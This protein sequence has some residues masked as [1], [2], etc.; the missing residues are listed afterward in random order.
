MW[1]LLLCIGLLTLLSGTIN[2]Q[3]YGDVYFPKYDSDD[4]E[5]G[6]VGGW[7]PRPPWPREQPRPIERPL[8]R[9]WSRRPDTQPTDFTRNSDRSPIRPST[10]GSSNHRSLPLEDCGTITLRRILGGEIAS[11]GQYPWSALLQYRSGRGRLSFECGG[12]LINKRY[13]ITAA[14]CLHKR[15]IRDYT[16]V[17]VRLGE[18]DTSK[19]EDCV[20]NADSGDSKCADPPQDFG[21]E[22][23]IMHPQYRG[24]PEGKNDIGLIRLNRDAPTTDYIRPICLPIEESSSRTSG[25]NMIVSGW[26]ITESG[27]KSTQLRYVAVPNVDIEECSSQLNKN[28]D[29]TQLCAGGQ[30]GKDS[31]KGDSGGPL[32]EA[33]SINNDNRFVI[34]GLVSFGPRVCGSENKPGVYTRVSAFTDW[35][36]STIN[37]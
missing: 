22:R 36:L 9:P 15:I 37:S 24:D 21:I 6:Y 8:P 1:S 3:Y 29:S 17:N 18:L 4:Y 14:H 7:R 10:S 23:Q 25:T 5:E 32:I 31:C 34:K 30:R 11:P 12:A 19:D 26:G 28:L 16:L 35:I 13:V 27:Q 20:E 33:G 2:G